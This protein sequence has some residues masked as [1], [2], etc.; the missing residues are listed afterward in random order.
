MPLG[1][2]AQAPLEPSQLAT[3][4]CVRRLYVLVMVANDV[5]SRLLDQPD[6]SVAARNRQL[7][8]LKRFKN[9][10]R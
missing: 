4:T 9:R 7:R 6:V 5:V 10:C 1:C 2:T 8:V 3:H